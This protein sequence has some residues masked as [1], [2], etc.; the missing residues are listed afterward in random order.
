M[1]R[2]MAERRE[3]PGELEPPFEPPPEEWVARAMEL[4]RLEEALGLLRAARSGGDGNGAD[5][6]AMRAALVA[7]RLEPD[8]KRL[9]ALAQLKELRD[10]DR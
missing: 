7:V 1:M 10:S 3:D 5:V 4:P 8:E 6:E 9:R 2:S